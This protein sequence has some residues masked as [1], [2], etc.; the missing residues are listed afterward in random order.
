MLGRNSKTSEK[1]T[2]GGVFDCL[3]D[4]YFTVLS[5][6]SFFYQLLGYSEEEFYQTF[7]NHLIDIIYEEEKQRILQ[8]VE[9]Q[10]HNNRV[11]MYE[12]RW[13][14]KNGDIKW[15]W[16]S[17][18]L[19]EDQETSYFHCIFH[20]ITNAKQ[21]LEKLQVSEKRFQAI[22][23]ETQDIVFEMDVKKQQVY[24]SENYEKKFGYSV[25]LENFPS[26]MLASDIVYHEDKC[27]LQEAF[28]SLR[29]GA[30]SM[31]CEYRLKYRNEGYR[32][33]E[34]SATAIRD[35]Q[36]NLSSIIGIIMDIHDKKKE[37][38]ETRR[39]AAL[40]PMTNVFNRR[41]FLHEFERL[42]KE[43][44]QLCIILVDV[45]DFK[46][47]NDK[48]GHLKGDYVLLDIASILTS[49][50]P[51]QLIGRYGGD[52]FI[53]CVYDYTSKEDVLKQIHE[54]QMNIEKKEQL[55]HK[56]KINC[57]IGLSFY[58]EHG[59]DF[60][61]LFNKADLAMYRAK[62]EGK[63][64][65][66]VF[67]DTPAFQ[68]KPQ[69]VMKKSFHDEVLEYAIHLFMIH[70]ENQQAI[71][72]L[73]QHVGSVFAYDRIVIYENNLKAFSW[74]R[75]EQYQM[76]T[77]EQ[78]PDD[79]YLQ[80]MGNIVFYEKIE[81]M[82]NTALQTWFQARNVCSASLIA[83]EE[84]GLSNLLL[85]FEDCHAERKNIEEERYTLQ[86]VS[87]IIAIL[88]LRERSVD[89]LQKYRLEQIQFLMNYT[90]GGLLVTYFEPGLPFC[91]ANPKML[92]MLGYHSEAELMEASQGIIY[93]LIFAADRQEIEDS[94]HKQIQE[95]GE[96]DIEY[97]MIHKDGNLVWMNDK[98][99]LFQT[100]EN[101]EAIVSICMDITKEKEY[102]SQLQVYR[103]SSNGGAFIN[104]VDE[105]FTLL[106]ANDL[107]YRIYEI[108]Q[109]DFIKQGSR[110]IEL[111]HPQDRAYVSAEIRKAYMQ[112]KEKVSIQFRALTK[113]G[114]IKWISLHGAFEQ[115]EEQ[116]VMNGFI[117]D[118]SKEHQLQEEI[119]HKELI[120]RT[121][122]R[123]SHINVWEY[124]VKTKTLYLTDS[125]TELHGYARVIENIPESLFA[126]EV[127]HPLSISCV[128][129]VYEALD[130][131]IAD[132][133]CEVLMKGKADE[134]HWQRIHYH[135]IYD[136]EQ[137]PSIAVAISED[138]TQAKKEKLRM[139]QEQIDR[140]IQHNKT[141]PI[142]FRCNL[143]EN[144]IDIVNSQIID[145]SA[146]RTYDDLL[147]FQKDYV[148]GEDDSIRFQNILNRDNLISH[149]LQGMNVL[150]CAYR[151][152]DA[153]GSIS[154]VEAL[155]YVSIDANGQDISIT[156]VMQNIEEIKKIEAQV[157]KAIEVN[158]FGIYKE[159]SFIDMV[160]IVLSH[161]VHEPCAF[162]LFQLTTTYVD[163]R[164]RK[165][166]MGEWITYL[167]LCFQNPYI[168]G[169]MKESYIGVFLYR[170]V[171]EN[172]IHDTL[173]TCTSLLNTSPYQ[174]TVD[175]GGVMDKDVSF[176]TLYK[177]AKQILLETQ[178]QEHT[179]H[180]IKVENLWEKKEGLLYND[181]HVAI[182]WSLP[183]FIDRIQKTHSPETA[184]RMVLQ[185]L[186]SYYRGKQVFVYDMQQEE[187]LYQDVMDD[188]SSSN[189]GA[190]FLSI[191]HVLTFMKDSDLP[192]Y[193]QEDTLRKE[194]C[195][196]A[197]QPYILYALKE[198]NQQIGVLGIYCPR[199]NASRLNFVRIIGSVLLS[200]LMKRN[201]YHK[202]KELQHID[203]VTHVY[204]G[205][206]L[207]QYM[208]E[209][210]EN[211]LHA[212]GVIYLD[213][214]G[215]KDIN[216]LYG[217]H[218]GDELLI[219]VSN[220]LKQ[221]VQ[222]AHIFRY[223]GDEFMVIT[224]NISFEV[225]LTTC[226]ELRVALME[227]CDIAMGSSWAQKQI[228]IQNL[229]NN[230]EEQ[231]SLEKQKY[232]LEKGSA[233][234]YKYTEA[235]QQ[236]LDAIQ[237]GH[238]K[239]YLQQKVDSTNLHVVGAEALVRYEDDT[240]GLVSPA[241]F[242]PFLETTGLIYYVDIYMYEEVN[243][244]LAE[245]KK[246]GIPLIPISLNFS[247]ITLLENQLV[248]HMNEINQRY[249]IDKDL[250][251]I[252]ITETIGEIERQTI[253]RI[254]AQ[255][256]QA[257]Y[258]LALDDFGSKY[259]NIAFLSDIHFHTLKFDKGLVDY[260][261]GNKSSR[262][263]LES[264]ISLCRK[265]NI[266]NVAEG[267]EQK[268]Q[269][270]ILRELGCTYIQGYYY[271]KPVPYEIFDN[272]R[273]HR[274]D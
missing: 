65:Y 45:D 48:F 66:C 125:V 7:Q 77:D 4:R 175:C 204:N 216:R 112:H 240:Y 151:R 107:F 94:M 74:H 120:Y 198:D 50:F 51:K 225:F 211:S 46:L 111:I 146:L 89:A 17:A 250:I 88:L 169:E 180:R 13:I 167:K 33:V 1:E 32:W 270:E 97:R 212:L 166:G 78:L 264:M 53:V 126:C 152:K 29:N 174:N 268:E 227:I 236:L 64:Q 165:Q 101:K 245:W 239:M 220:L 55:K 162:L 130:E 69:K 206:R 178:K 244:L 73:L 191:K 119:A 38:I 247:R 76:K 259:S 214:N 223:A 80:E 267:V 10:I 21:S 254:C 124:D 172:M 104:R 81:D 232:Y 20:D 82:E 72:A 199:Q 205:N 11:F 127:I 102:Q 118:V 262:W 231:V 12:N 85:C 271:S 173:S 153:H 63:N 229:I 110:C 195:I 155:G 272:S 190:S 62:R 30:D 2:F 154:W 91:F 24:Y 56:V 251:E 31:K 209:I 44:E 15:I 68:I 263:I 75:Q 234:H 148:A 201:I 108:S 248:E 36:G 192:V 109:E 116:T 58:P 9:H 269:V 95:N 57:S 150:S 207:R 70:P 6:D 140:I 135:M 43:K 156:G 202:M 41:A 241:K 218:Y 100:Q 147:G 18:Q 96:Y 149:F 106:Y 230:A 3:Y 93:N 188:S 14:C 256:E 237:R 67:S 134:Y 252:E 79:M 113:Q 235:M 16:I 42:K 136:A 145:T 194:F 129:H 138:I 219:K 168:I 157:P 228:S 52:E 243:R 265:L 26:G 59:D 224:E 105:A 242:I 35:E 131:G 177:D 189:N 185:E 122:L 208:Q 139:N 273:N 25:P 34:A 197:V 215:L 49:V 137:K 260:L 159:D 141:Y 203:A 222:H 47:I 210:Q 54:V 261:I 183:D 161:H 257:G 249:G 193:V 181:K 221:Y 121:A 60:Y 184:I 133:Q 233:V 246:Q 238:F 86:I 143:S 71:P 123:T 92:D 186:L 23:S 213:I 217:T 176:E 90:P 8:E 5:A 258:R 99:K 187:V 171:D 179:T 274:D 27:R 117:L 182:D 19:L 87:E 200:I 128:K 266:Y 164:Q 158:A 84:K 115:Y 28:Q 40:D 61:T 160:D 22:L 103:E 170:Q 83:L 226:R 114:K 98:G 142:S 253:I 39:E 37:I 255:I 144:K 163:E 132:I 196:E